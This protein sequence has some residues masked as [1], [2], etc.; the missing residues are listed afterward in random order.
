M[1]SAEMLARLEARCRQLVPDLCAT[2]Y[3]KQTNGRAAPFGGLNVILSGDLWQLPPPRG[4]FLGQIPW[5]LLTHVHSKKWPLSL[6][7]QQL[8]WAAACDGGIQGVTE[9]V[10][11][12]RTQDIWLQE[13]Q[14]ELRIGKLSENNHAFLHGRPTNVPGSW[15]QSLGHPTC[16]EA[17]CQELYTQNSTPTTIRQK[18]CPTCQTERASKHLVA[19]GPRDSRFTNDLA[20]AQ[21]I[22]STNV[23]KCHVNR[24]RAEEWARLHGQRLYYAIARD[25]ASSQTLHAKPDLAKEKLAW[26]QRSDADCGDRCGAL[27]L[28]VGMP[29]QAREH[30]HRGDFKILRGCHGVVRGW[31]A[32][33]SEQ[34]TLH[35]DII[36]NELPAYIFVRFT[37]RTE[38]QLPGIAEKNVFPVGVAR[39][40]WYL[41][42]G[43]PNPSLKVT[44]T[45]FP[46]APDFAGTTHA[47]QGCTAEHGA[48]VDVEANPDPIAV[49]VGMTRCRTRDKLMIYRP[50]P[51]APL[52]AGLPLG[53][54]LLLDIWKQERIDWDALRKKY[55]DE[56]PC[57]ECNESKRKDGFTKGQ[58]RHDSYR[59]CK[60]CAARK[61]DAGTP[62]RCSQCGV[63]HATSHFPSKHLNPRWSSYR[64]CF[65]C[66]AKKQC[67]VC[68]KSLTRECFSAAAWKCKQDRRKCLTCQRKTR[69]FWT[70]A[71][72][73]QRKQRDQYRT[74]LRRR[75]SGEDGHQMCDACC[76][77]QAQQRKRQRI[78]SKCNARVA[79]LRQRIHREHILQE[80]KDLIAREVHARK[81]L[82]QTTPGAQET[83]AAKRPKQSAGA[84]APHAKPNISIEPPQSTVP[85]SNRQTQRQTTTENL[86]KPQSKKGKPTTTSA[87]PH[88]PTHGRALDPE[89]PGANRGREVKDKQKQEYTC[90]HC[91]G[92]VV[93]NVR[94]GQIDHRTVCGHRFC[95]RDGTVQEKKTHE[96]T[97]PHC[98]GLVASNVTTGQIDHR[99]VC[100]NR[101]CV[102]DGTVQEKQK[103][104]YTCPHC[105]GLVASNVTTGQID[106]RTVC[107][108]RFCVRD[109]TVQEKQTHEYT[110]P[111]CGGLV[112]SNITTGQIDH[113][114][115]CGNRFC[116][117]DGTV[118]E[119]EKRKYTRPHCG[120]LVASTLTTGQIDHRTV[121]GNRFY[122][123][124]GKV[125]D[126]KKNVQKTIGKK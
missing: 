120:G 88:A 101:F 47:L 14:S 34:E 122:V 55:L 118:K 45:Q 73:Q 67:L 93:S 74:F 50:F 117:R 65:S 31:S 123:T 49:Y 51:L 94:T 39:K 104:E 64:V 20:R 102:R 25:V 24:I 52:Q 54:Q 13:L 19:I 110:C 79:S 43:R 36:W 77:R 61:R 103:H 53:R 92:L 44:R 83:T 76:A 109:G 16:G 63:W 66:E 91:G 7:G 85:H 11:C 100:G 82:A 38:W 111:H 5:Q 18:E 78:A 30:I 3:S 58:W 81:R 89:V 126:Q 21:A 2:K 35:K 4:T 95:V 125:K 113:R 97:C 28:C 70:C 62:Y 108:N 86:P 112:A 12:E 23:V 60:E 80:I 68:H 98:G 87:Q 105:G 32:T 116:V 107:G 72:C 15:Q 99:T 59:V 29:V 124:A 22:F 57:M 10:Q 6:Q 33:T 106:H 17:K 84:V 96:Y 90:P 42:A 75:P 71:G 27:P 48:I 9:L 121:C 69:G 41:D 46:L 115:V 56:R 26:L 8:V 40:P 37:T 119:K 1:V 114:T